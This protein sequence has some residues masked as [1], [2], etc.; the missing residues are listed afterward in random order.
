ML[1]V[2]VG[3][4]C[5]VSARQGGE[6]PAA[7]V[8]V[9]CAAVLC[10]RN[11]G[12]TV[13]EHAS[14]QLFF[15][16]LR[17]CGQGNNPQELE[18]QRLRVHSHCLSSSPPSA[19]PSVLAAG[20]PARPRVQDTYSGGRSKWKADLGQPFILSLAPSLFT[21][22]ILF[23]L[24]WDS[25]PPGSAFIV[26]FKAPRW[27]QT[28][29]WIGLACVFLLSISKHTLHILQQLGGRLV[30]L[31]PLMCFSK[32]Y[33]CFHAGTIV[34]LKVWCGEIKCVKCSILQLMW[35]SETLTIQTLLTGF[36]YVAHL[37]NWG[38]I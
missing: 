11:G 4:V 15:L 12:E 14:C 35:C 24:Y 17:G 31:M 13:T 25:V 22:N 2:S 21:P 20:L 28:C 18:Q 32:C 19:A 38:Y 27:L 26:S 29:L 5:V 10:W 36:I 23:P 7:G 33:P 3:C 1:I 9:P 34:K 6:Q 16:P 30:R 8:C 37:L